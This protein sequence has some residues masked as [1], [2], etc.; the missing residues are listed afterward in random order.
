MLVD[1]GD[2]YRRDEIDRY[3]YPIFHQ[4]EGVRMLGHKSVVTIDDAV[5]DLKKTLEKLAENLFGQC[6]MRWV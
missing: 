4:M 6:E 2:V 5:N 3:H 1:A